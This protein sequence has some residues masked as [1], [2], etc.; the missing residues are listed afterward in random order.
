[1]RSVLPEL[2]GRPGVR[3]LAREPRAARGEPWRGRVVHAR[4]DGDRHTRG[5]AGDLGAHARPLPPQVPRRLRGDGGE[6]PERR[7]GGDRRPGHQHLRRRLGSPRRCS[8]SSPRGGWTA[9]RSACSPPCSS[10]TSSSRPRSPRTWATGAGASCSPPTTQRC[11]R[12]S[13]ATAARRSAARATASSPPSRGP[14]R[15]IACARAAIASVG[16]LGLDLR[17]G[18]HTG[19]VELVGTKVEGIAVHI[20]ARVAAEAPPVRGA[21]VEHRPRPRRGLRNRLR[22]PRRARPE[23]RAGR[24]EAVRGSTQRARPNRVGA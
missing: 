24:V 20:G 10:R 19:E 8:A 7:D 5:A 2:R 13:P 15:A 21:R 14:A 23:G 6:D 9:H 11:G 16:D 18:V 4:A 17:A 3:A 22:G 1:M 12:R